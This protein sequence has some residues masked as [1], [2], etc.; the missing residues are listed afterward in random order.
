MYLHM[1]LFIII[2]VIPKNRQGEPT[3]ETL[4]ENKNHKNKNKKNNDKVIRIII[5]KIIYNHN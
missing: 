2:I 4:K 5:N 3:A 1:C